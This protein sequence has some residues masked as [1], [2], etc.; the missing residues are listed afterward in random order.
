MDPTI[1]FKILEKKDYQRFL[2]QILDFY[3]PKYKIPFT[4]VTVENSAI[5]CLALDG[6]K[7]VGAI[8]TISD[9]TR[10]AE[11]V[12][13]IVD[14]KYRKQKIGTK[15]VQLIVEQLNTYK[16]K[17]IGLTTETGVVWLPDFYQKLGFKILKD[18]VYMEFDK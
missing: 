15:L 4:E 10:H 7:I 18:S 2:K 17:N 16:V 9:L 8:R 6:N 3:E 14:E 13:L 12:D 5:I 1:E 11:I